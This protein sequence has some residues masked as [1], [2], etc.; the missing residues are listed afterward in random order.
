MTD[1]LPRSSAA[2][3]SKRYR[4]RRES[5]IVM[6]HVEVGPARLLGLVFSH[7][8][9]VEDFDDPKKVARA[10]ELLLDSVG[11]RYVKAEQMSRER[12]PPGSA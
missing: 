2:E 1:P 10:V 8:L 12:N 9:R 6:A 11:A 7:V 4:E 3:R 5:G